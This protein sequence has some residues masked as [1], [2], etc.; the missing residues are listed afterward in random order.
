MDAQKYLDDLLVKANRFMDKNDEYRTEF[1][2]LFKSDLSDTIMGMSQD[3]MRIFFKISQIMNDTQII[4]TE[5]AS[6]LNFAKK[7]N[8]EVNIDKF[9][10]VQGL[11]GFIA[12]YEPFGTDYNIDE[13]GEVQ[14]RNEKENNEKFSNFAKNLKNII[15][16]KIFDESGE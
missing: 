10:E 9:N 7:S 14:V 5:I 3:R 16:S 12:I 15:K 8:I 13:K 11:S 1:P 6:F 2:E 4:F